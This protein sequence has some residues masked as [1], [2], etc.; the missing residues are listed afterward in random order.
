MFTELARNV[1]TCRLD[2]SCNAA[3]DVWLGVA[4]QTPPATGSTQACPR[5]STH[6]NRNSLYGIRQPATVTA[7]EDCRAAC[8]ADQRC[9]GLDWNHQGPIHCWLHRDRLNGLYGTPGVTQH[10]LV[11][12]CPSTTP[13]KMSST[14]EWQLQTSF[15]IYVFIVRREPD[16]KTYFNSIEFF[17]LQ[18][19]RLR[20]IVLLLFYKSGCNFES[21][22]KLDSGFWN[23]VTCGS[24]AQFSSWTY[25]WM[26]V[27]R[28]LSYFTCKSYFPVCQA[29][30]IYYV[31]GS[32]TYRNAVRGVNYGGTGGT[33]PPQNL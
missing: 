23:S 5:W 30:I 8:L 32:N 10:V 20:K 4:A 27:T 6:N 31:V 1:L 33:C 7:V 18:K 26:S 9:V 14:R 17:R 13:G 11:E 2:K 25:G 3:E 21:I 12:R 16:F 19:L 24:T 22:G 15:F 28:A 29:L